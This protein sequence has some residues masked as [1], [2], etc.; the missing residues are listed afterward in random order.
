MKDYGISPGILFLIFICVF[1]LP[2]SS[3]IAWLVSLPQIH[4]L[5]ALLPCYIIRMSSNFYAF[6]R[7]YRKSICNSLQVTFVISWAFVKAVQTVFTH[8]IFSLSYLSSATLK[9]GHSQDLISR[10]HSLMEFI[11][12]ALAVSSQAK[13]HKYGTRTYYLV[14]S[15]SLLNIISQLYF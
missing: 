2:L 13:K 9:I 12:K 14:F 15:F 6:L 1:S 5:I 4:D 8:S 10:L 7:L 11:F 3:H